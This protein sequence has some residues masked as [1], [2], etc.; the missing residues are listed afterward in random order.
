MIESIFFQ[1]PILYEMKIDTCRYSNHSFCLRSNLSP[2]IM[3]G[4]NNYTNK[5][6]YK[7]SYNWFRTNCC[8][9]CDTVAINLFLPRP[10]S[11]I[12]AINKI[13]L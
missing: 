10:T 4:H 8:A 11:Q 9:R 13:T 3:K 5:N 6:L 2:L 1:I 7:F 12:S